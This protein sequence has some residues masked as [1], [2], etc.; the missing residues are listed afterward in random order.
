[1]KITCQVCGKVV[2]ARMIDGKPF[3]MYHTKRT[4]RK[5]VIGKQP[6]CMGTY[7]PG[8]INVTL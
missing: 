7:K 2:T 5:C 3:P 8:V 1:M 6:V 4:A